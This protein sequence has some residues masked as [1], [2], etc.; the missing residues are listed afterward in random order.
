MSTII[1]AGSYSRDAS[2]AITRQERA[3]FRVTTS[4]IRRISP[5][6]SEKHLRRVVTTVLRGW[7]FTENVNHGS[8]RFRA[9]HPPVIGTPVLNRLLDLLACEFLA[10]RSLHQIRH[11]RI[12]RKP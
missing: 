5:D 3:V 7:R 8:D 12:L 1:R 6:I 11:F 9:L 2:S 4:F 10:D